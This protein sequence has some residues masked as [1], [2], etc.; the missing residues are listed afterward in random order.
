VCRC[1]PLSPNSTHGPNIHTAS[2]L[3]NSIPG[4]AVGFVRSLAA[5]SAFAVIV[6][7]VRLSLVTLYLLVA[8]APAALAAAPANDDFN[9]PDLLT[10]LPTIRQLDNSQATNQPG[11]PHPP[12]VTTGT[13]AT[14]WYRITGTG[15]SVTVLAAADPG[16]HWN[17][18]LAVY[19][20]HAN[21]P[22]T[23]S[24]LIAC[25][26][27]N[28]QTFNTVAG[29]DY[30]IQVGSPVCWLDDDRCA[31]IDD[32]KGKGRIEVLVAPPNDDRAA[33]MPAQAGANNIVD[34]IRGATTESGEVLTCTATGN[35][36]NGYWSTVWFRYSAPGTG[37]LTLT[38][39]GLDWPVLAVYR[40]SEGSPAAC[41]KASEE[42]T[43][44]RLTLP[45]SAGEHLI[46]VGTGGGSAGGRLSVRADFLPNADVDGDGYPIPADCDDTDPAIHPGVDDVRD[47]GVD[48]DCDGEDAV[49]LDRDNDGHAVP[50]DC[51]NND[52]AIYP[53][54]TEI[55]DNAVDENCDGHDAVNLDR[56][57]DGYPR[58]LDC[59]DSDPNVKPG[60][61]DIPR[62]GV[63]EDCDGED[64]DYARIQA[65]I[66]HAE[67]AHGR[68]LTVVRRLVVTG[69]AREAAIRLRCRGSRCGLRRTT[70]RPHDDAKRVALTKH[71]RALRFGPAAVLEVAVTAPQMYGKLL[72]LSFRAG[73]PPR[74]TWL[75]IDPVTGKRSRW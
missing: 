39:S 28:G 14:L 12:C 6:P 74:V 16:S 45:V 2:L 4:S 38:A 57:G 59:A 19:R 71:V 60:A 75:Q 63:A 58:P 70:V 68:R 25:A 42:G 9:T 61:R 48:E 7:G 30:L 34:D 33:A 8:L 55:P 21:S 37:T 31:I 64:A 72:R 43:P 10:S 56:D 46:Q 54:A 1:H 66:R 36:G 32:F 73:K 41:V 27:G 47:N 44:G 15:R 13:T 62:S 69:L 65:D 29:T 18:V 11:D 50:A 3:S 35:G 24:N 67:K 52:P 5:A 26:H 40:A 22:P 20:Q 17:S 49:N 53:G 23:F 51:N